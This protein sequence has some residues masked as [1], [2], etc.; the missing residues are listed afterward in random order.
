MKCDNKLPKLSGLQI[1]NSLARTVVKAPK[2]CH[3]T[4]ILCS[5]HWLRITEHIKYSVLTLTYK[6][7]T[8]TQPPYR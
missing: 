6:V 8:T 4:P 1:Q 5:L 3:I 2:F 7:L